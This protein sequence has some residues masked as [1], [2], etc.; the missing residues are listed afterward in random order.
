MSRLTRTERIRIRRLAEQGLSASELAW[1]YDVSTSTIHRVLRDAESSISQDV[2]ID[3]ESYEYALTLCRN[4]DERTYVLFLAEHGLLT[5]LRRRLWQYRAR[6]RVA[7]LSLEHDVPVRDA[8]VIDLPL[9]D[10]DMRL[11]RMRVEGYS[12]REIADMLGVSHT[13]ISRQFQRIRKTVTE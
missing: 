3:W 9:D 8:S 12:Y 4:D 2:I 6:K 1:T 7:P 11:V 5:Y 13:T 10:A